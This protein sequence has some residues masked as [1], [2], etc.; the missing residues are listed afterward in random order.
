VERVGD[1]FLTAAGLCTNL[2]GELKERY[3]FSNI[4]GTAGPMNQVYEQI[5]QVSNTNTIAKGS[6]GPVV[7]KEGNADKC[8]VLTCRDLFAGRHD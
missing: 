6:D 7:D 3:E 8:D 5:F 4:I 1:E 2:R